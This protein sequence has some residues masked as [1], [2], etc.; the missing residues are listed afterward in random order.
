MIP[1]LIKTEL[2][3]ASENEL[4][5]KDPQVPCPFQRLQFSFVYK[6]KVTSVFPNVTV[7]AG[8]KISPQGR[9]KLKF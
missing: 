1:V 2:R 7:V 4:N 6:K 3:K 5:K 8:F 9:T